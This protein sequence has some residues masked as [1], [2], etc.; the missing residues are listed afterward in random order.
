[1]H[2]R[3]KAESSRLGPE[4]AVELAVADED[5]VHTRPRPL[6]VRGGV[7]QVPVAFLRHEAPDRQREGRRRRNPEGRAERPG[8]RPG[9]EPHEI[10]AVGDQSDLARR[11][12]EAARDRPRRGDH[13]GRERAECQVHGAV[14]LGDPHVPDRGASGQTPGEPPIGH[15][16]RAVGVDQHGVGAPHALLEP[17]QQVGLLLDKLGLVVQI[18]EHGDLGPEDGGHDWGE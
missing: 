10:D 17:V 18:N 14:S 12:G 8:R 11:P 5:P 15:G 3:C 4:L 9:R 1:M 2:A 6:E 7:Q 16:A 13:P